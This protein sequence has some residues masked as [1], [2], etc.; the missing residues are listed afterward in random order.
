MKEKGTKI[1]RNRIHRTGN[2]EEFKEIQRRK[3]AKITPSFCLEP[4]EAS[5]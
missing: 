3:E 2:A 4:G 5:G 1:L